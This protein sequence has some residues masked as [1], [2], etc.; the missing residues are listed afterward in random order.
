MKLDLMV[1]EFIED[2]L[3][4]APVPLSPQELGVTCGSLLAWRDVGCGIVAEQEKVA[5]VFYGYQLV[6]MISRTSKDKLYSSLWTPLKDLVHIL[7]LESISLFQLGDRSSDIFKSIIAK[8]FGDVL[9][10]ANSHPVTLIT[11]KEI[12]AALTRRFDRL[13]LDTR[14]IASPLKLIQED[15]RMEDLLDFM[16]RNR[17]RRA[18]IKENGHYFSCTERE[19][20]RYFFSMQGLEVLRESPEVLLS[21]PVG[22]M[23]KEQGEKLPVV[24]GDLDVADAWKAAQSTKGLAVIV[25]EEKIATPWDLVVKPYLEGK[26]PT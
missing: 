18:V 7:P 24:S 12:L 22:E 9:I 16:L 10:I 21:K 23:V 17:I 6:F 11:L 8:R 15:T 5:G 3:A 19:L 26:L 13:D 4:P 20:L 2:G 14:T 1:S 25:D